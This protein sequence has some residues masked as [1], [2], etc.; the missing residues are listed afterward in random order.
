MFRTGS[1]YHTI[2]A[3]SLLQATARVRATDTWAVDGMQVIPLVH[4]DL[5]SP[6]RYHRWTMLQQALGSVQLAYDAL[7][8]AVPE[9][10]NFKVLHLLLLGRHGFQC[11]I[12]K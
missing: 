8:L 11:L 12:Q 3:L 4:C 1:R 2:Q 9:V 6:K 7:A 10:I 5:I